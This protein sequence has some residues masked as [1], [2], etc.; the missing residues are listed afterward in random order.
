MDADLNRSLKYRVLARDPDTR[1][2]A[3]VLTTLHGDIPTPCFMPV[4]TQG[5]VKAV[6]PDDLKEVGASMILANT[7]HLLIRPGPDIVKRLGGLHGFMS[8]NGPILTDS[9]GYQVFSLAS[10]RKIGQEGVVFKSHLDGTEISLTP[11]KAIA[12]QETLG[13]D[14]MMAFDECTP[15]PS[16]RRETAASAELTLNWAHRCLE[17]QNPDHSPALFGIIQGGMY[18]DLRRRSAEDVSALDFPGLAIGGLAVG[19]EPE[20]RL[21]MIDAAAEVIP[22]EKPLYLMGLGAPVDLVEGVAR[23]AD[24]FDCVMPTRNARNGQLFTTSGRLVIKNARYKDDP[25][26]VEEGCGCY[27][28]RTFSRGYLRHLFIARELLA[29]RLNS[30]HN[31]YYYLALL[32]K[33]REALLSGKFTQFYADFYDSREDE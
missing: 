33:A 27:T 13:P 21:D 8:W 4:G 23:G 32:G 15:Y 10:L 29:Y 6:G 5:T 31:L 22:S 17:A 28:C 14:I 12:V 1:A 26:P 24:M 18:P 7:Y 11:E 25:R 20:V 9:G 2:R 30:I 3:G 19:E 16:R